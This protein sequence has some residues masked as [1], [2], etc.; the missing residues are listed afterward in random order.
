MPVSVKTRLGFNSVDLSWHEFL[1]GH[2]LDMLAIHG[3]TRG[4]MSD[5]PAQWDQIGKVREL[6]DRIAPDTLLVG[7]GDIMSRTQGAGIS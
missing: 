1:L 7:N 5:V 2:K 3:R 4:E 6:R